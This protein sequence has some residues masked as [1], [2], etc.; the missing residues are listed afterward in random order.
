VSTK[1]AT[2][3]VAKEADSTA[4]AGTGQEPLIPR[5]QPIAVAPRI[6]P[7]VSLEDR[8]PRGVPLPPLQSTAENDDEQVAAKP[9]AR[10]RP[11]APSPTQNT[12]PA[13]RPV[14]LPPPPTL[15]ETGEGEPT[16]IRP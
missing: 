7:E 15:Y 4:N 6:A 2:P 14:R 3:S 8:S 5:T 10:T 13:A 12:S 11:A 1:S 16:Q 9:I